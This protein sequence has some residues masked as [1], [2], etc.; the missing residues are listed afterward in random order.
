MREGP[1]VAREVGGV[2]PAAHLGNVYFDRALRGAGLAAKA[3]SQ[4]VIKLRFQCGQVRGLFA[5]FGRRALTRPAS[6]E[7]R[8]PLWSAQPVAGGFVRGAHRLIDI[9]PHALAIA[10]AFHRCGIGLRQF[11]RDPGI[12]RPAKGHLIQWG[13][14]LRRVGA[15][16]LAGVEQVIRVK[17]RLDP[18]HG[19]IEAGAKDIGAIFTAKSLAMFAPDQAA[20][21]ARQP[22]HR[23]RDIADHRRILRAAHVERGA[24]MHTAHIG[25]A[26]HPVTQPAVVQNG[27]KA[28]DESGQVFRWHGGILDKGRALPCRVHPPQQPDAFRPQ[29][30]QLADGRNVG[31]GT[32]A[33]E[34]AGGAGQRLKARQRRAPRILIRPCHLDKIQPAHRA[35]AILAQH[36]GHR[37]PDRV[38]LRQGQDLVIDKFY[39]RRVALQQARHILER[40]CHVGI[41]T[42]DQRPTARPGHQP[43]L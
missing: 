35:A 41:G 36:I 15:G 6:Q 14:R 5:L 20:M 34:A 27:A 4:A 17:G 8:A 22:M 28:C 19:G 21:R 18:A 30:P 25:M 9:A 16:D 40:C 23:I 10:V 42:D 43:Q 24:H 1:A 39:G 12:Q 7:R 37:A 13:Q 3:I 29:R 38:L 26:E 33:D 2:E 32:G 11:R 31:D